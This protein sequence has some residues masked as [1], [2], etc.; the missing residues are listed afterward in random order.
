MKKLVTAFALCAAISAMAVESENIVGYQTKTTIGQFA[1]SGSM[2]VSVGST[3]GEWKLGDIKA[4]GMV[5]GDDIIQFLSATDLSLTQAATYI[6]EANSIAIIGDNSLVGWWNAGVDTQLDDEVFP[7]GTAF[8]ANFV[9][10]G[11]TLT[12]SGE[13]ALGA[14]TL[15][16]SGLQFPFIA[17]CVPRD[18]TLGDLTATGMVPGDDIIQFLST[19]DLSLIEAA[20][21]IDEAASIA[22]IG[23]NSLVGWWNAGVDTQL[24]DMVLTSGASFLGNFVSTG[25]QIT[26]PSAI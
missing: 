6:D 5:P 20:T 10:T 23:D 16:L 12:Y 14:T 22:I 19:T 7:A 17:N 11:I 15:D 4:A 24:D 21:Y 8:L 25:V 1:T 2:F 26:F 9:S 18:L 13:V 3:T